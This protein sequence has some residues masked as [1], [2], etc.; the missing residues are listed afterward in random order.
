M[1][2]LDGD[3]TINKLAETLEIHYPAAHSAVKSL[4]SEGYI[5]TK[6]IRAKYN[7]TIVTLTQRGKKWASMLK[8]ELK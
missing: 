8:K 3:F 2:L 4:E 1:G 5:K 6:K 7:P